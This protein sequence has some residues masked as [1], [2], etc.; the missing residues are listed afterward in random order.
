MSG[1]LINPER[2]LIFRITHMA[3]VP[4]LLAHGLHCRNSS[5]FDPNFRNVGNPDYLPAALLRE[6]FTDRLT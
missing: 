2:A 4:W 3:N 6:A 5:E 1:A